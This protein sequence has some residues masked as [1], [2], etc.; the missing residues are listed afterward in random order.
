MESAALRAGAGGTAPGR[1]GAGGWPRDRVSAVDSRAVWCGGSSSARCAAVGSDAGGAEVPAECGWAAVAEP[2]EVSRLGAW[3]LRRCGGCTGWGAARESG[4]PDPIVQFQTWFTQATEAGLPEPNAMVLA[5]ADPD[6][7]P[8]ART[9]L[10]KRLDERGLVFY[11]NQ[12]SRKADD[13][14]ANPYC[15]LVFPW[16]A[17][18]RQVRVEGTVTKLPADEVDEYFAVRPRAH[19]SARG[20]PS[21]ASR[22][23]PGRSSTC[24][25]RRTSA[26]GRR[27]PRS[28]RRTS[29][30]LSGRAGGVR[31]LAGPHRPAAR[32]TCLP[33]DELRRFLGTGPAP[34]LRF[35]AEAVPRPPP[36]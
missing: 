7:R 14:A 20:P 19:S 11:T 3:I 21:R 12:Q 24:S 8:S 22:W 31:V 16:H 15:A 26:S 1:A 36:R 5:T 30:G 9:V 33:A 6:G 29:G 13:L 25:T 34:T 27:A 4:R 32:P 35:L 23:S 18:E 17:M 28:P 2:R 10:L